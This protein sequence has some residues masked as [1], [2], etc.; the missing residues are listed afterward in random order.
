MPSRLAKQLPTAIVIIQPFPKGSNVDG[1][2]SADNITDDPQ[3]A[4][5]HKQSCKAISIVEGLRSRIPTLSSSYMYLYLLVA[6]DQLSQQLQ[7]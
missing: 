4:Y 2:L 3:T 1:E 5:Q 6:G 7:E